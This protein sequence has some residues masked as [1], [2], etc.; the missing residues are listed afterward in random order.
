[1]L[2][3][4]YR[5]TGL[6]LVVALGPAS[7]CVAPLAEDANG[8]DATKARETS[9]SPADDCTAPMGGACGCGSKWDDGSLIQQALEC[10]CSSGQCPASLREY[11]E[12]MCAD[13]GR[14]ASKGCGKVTVSQ[15]TGF[16]NG[17]AEYI[18]S[19]DSGVLVGAY[20]ASDVGWGPCCAVAY[21]YGEALFLRQ[22]GWG[23]SNSQCDELTACDL[24]GSDAGPPCR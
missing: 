3:R 8:A 17:G 1:M 11:A 5:L 18:F 13:G 4:A 20:G 10:R 6:T 21:V 23:P 2:A 24:C 15:H 9:V 19:A 7:G 12:A 16:I 14:P 22:N